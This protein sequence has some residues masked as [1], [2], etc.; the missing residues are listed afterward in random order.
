MLPLTFSVI[1]VPQITTKPKNQSVEEG[2]TVILACA[3]TAVPP[4]S[5]SWT[6]DGNRLV[7]AENSNFNLHKNGTL[8]ITQAKITDSGSY[9]C[10]VDHPGGWT[11]SA[12]A[13]VVVMGKYT[14][15]VLVCLDCTCVKIVG[16]EKKKGFGDMG[17]FSPLSCRSC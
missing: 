14:A 11:D 6:K 10:S 5:I 4:A 13:K 12:T 1:E 7:I 17:Y 15:G 3:A 9:R 8:T 16:N 2:K